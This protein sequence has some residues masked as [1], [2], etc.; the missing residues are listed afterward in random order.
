M[1]TVPP[2]KRSALYRLAQ[3]WP[4]PVRTS[5]YHLYQATLPPLRA[6][7]NTFC[8]PV[9]RYLETHLVDQCNLDC[10]GCGH[11]SPIASDWYADPKIHDRDM[12]RL[13]V[14]FAN[15]EKIRLMGGEPLLHPEVCSFI[16]STRRR[17]PNADVRVVTNGILLP[18]QPPEFW[19]ACRD[20]DVTIDMSVYPPAHGKLVSYV[21]T[22][23]QNGV[24]LNWS[25]VT[26]FRAGHNL[27]IDSDREETY[28]VCAERCFCPFLREG[29]VYTCALGPLVEI[30]NEKRSTNVPVSDGIDI[31]DSKTTGRA[32]LKEVTTS[33]PTCR[34]CLGKTED[35]AWK[36]GKGT[37]EE[38]MPA[39]SLHQ[40]QD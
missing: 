13:A 16:E 23:E 36:R 29:R 14:L 11:Y 30:L 10:S 21:E 17:F 20:N 32:V 34:G 2:K 31:H 15:I 39:S 35:F 26:H 28:K 4:K 12:K 40:I 6:A 9:L 5:L 22:A 37:L 1:N 7:R 8:K 25:V 38:W 3:S 18:S 33:I 27:D 24:P 19:K